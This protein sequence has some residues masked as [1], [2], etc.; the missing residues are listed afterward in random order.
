MGN[1]TDILIRKGQHKKISKATWIFCFEILLLIL[2]CVIHSLGAGYYA[3]FYPINGTFQNF[4][5][6]R[7]LL[8]GQIPYKDF[9][10]YL[11]MGHLYIGSVFTTLYGGDY[12]GSLQAFSFLTFGGLAALAL[13]VSMA[14]VKRKEVAGAITNIILI[15]FLVEPLFYKNAISGTDEILEALEYALGPGNSARF[16]RGMILP[17]AC[18]LI[19][20]GYIFFKRF[21]LAKFRKHKE[22]FLYIGVGIVAGFS[23]VWSNDY[24]VSCWLCLLLMSFWLAECRERKFLKSIIAMATATGSSLISLFITV[25]IFTLGHFRQW[26]SATFEISGYQSWYF[27]SNKSYYLYD[28]DFS[29]IML[30]QAGLAIVYLVRLFKAKGTIAACRRY[31]ILAFANMVC[32]CAVNEYKVLSGGTAREVALSVLF[33]NIVIETGLLIVGS[34]NQKKVVRTLMT[35]SLILGLAWVV[36]T[37]KDEFV[38]YFM[39]DKEGVYV[40]ELGGNLTA[41]GNDLIETDLFLD[42]EEFFATY[43]S[44]QEVVNGSFQPSGIDY[45]IHVLGDE[46]RES[47][48]E[49]FV[50]GDFKYAATI[51]EDYADWESWTKMANWFFYRKLFQDWHPVYGNTYE[52]YW[53]RND[54]DDVNSINTGFALSVVDVDESTKKIVVQC[55]TPVNGTADVYI[56]YSVDKKKNRSAILNIQR[57]LK[58]ENTGTVYASG[59][60]YYESNFLRSESAEYIPVSVV[61]GYG[62]VTLTSNPAKSTSLSLNQAQCDCIYTVMSD[63]L[64]LQEIQPGENYFSVPNIEKNANAVNGITAVKFGEKEYVVKETETTKKKIRIYVD[65]PVESNDSLENI[66]FLQR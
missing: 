62:E 22:L 19:F 30:I 14:V 1:K 38:I 47:Y 18:F 37:A 36:A 45:I 66:L 23:F 2:I 28:V 32:F 63:Y 13:M 53:A 56:D 60:S 57:M 17:I 31:G 15:I 46:Q 40:E 26:F 21:L 25:E 8:S 16:I 6:V 29:Y 4:N 48:L 43:A 58:I 7:R 33:L 51:R 41:L 59:G 49:A 55:E 44:A 24:G 39:T 11:G 42:G 9:Q 64:V 65:R 35:A 54:E 61:N 52:L 12:Q 10:D 20:I 50:N 3:D 5:P 27:N 34:V